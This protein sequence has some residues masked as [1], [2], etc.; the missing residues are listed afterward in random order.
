MHDAI[1]E[2]TLRKRAKE[3]ASYLLQESTDF[4]KAKAQ[5]TYDSW[6]EYLDSLDSL[7]LSD[8]A[9]QEAD[10]WDWVIYNGKALDLCANVYGST[11]N[12]AESLYL[13]CDPIPAG[14]YEIATGIA[15]WIV[16]QAVMSELE[17]QLEDL[18]EL[19]TACQ[20]ST[21]K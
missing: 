1:N 19:A 15:Y 6:Q 8:L 10:S 11:L 14:L 18:R 21:T 12:E 5:N 20:E 4:D 3:S 13:E 7:D 2:S 9:H 17:S 16:Y